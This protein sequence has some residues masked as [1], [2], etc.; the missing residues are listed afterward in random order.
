MPGRR[1]AVPVRT[2]GLSKGVEISRGNLASG[3]RG[4]GASGDSSTIHTR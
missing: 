4:L 1:T 3:V 2:C